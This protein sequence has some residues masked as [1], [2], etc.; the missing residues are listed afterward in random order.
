ME[1][2]F[3]F[4]FYVQGLS[5]LIE[6]STECE[7]LGSSLSQLSQQVMSVQ[8]MHER[9]HA[10]MPDSSYDDIVQWIAVSIFIK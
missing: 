8:E 9:L 10:L 2:I 1:W 6:G 5:Y 4:I 7:K 3:S